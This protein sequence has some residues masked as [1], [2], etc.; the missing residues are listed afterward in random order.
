M[1]DEKAR[2]LRNAFMGSKWIRFLLK[3]MG[4]FSEA[5]ETKK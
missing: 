3:I 1:T 4:G 2:E 5:K